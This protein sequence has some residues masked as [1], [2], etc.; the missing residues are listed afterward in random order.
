MGDHDENASSEDSSTNK[1]L[2]PSDFISS[3][4]MSIMG[5]DSGRFF[6]QSSRR[7]KKQE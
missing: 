6:M 1:S 3:E 4:D 5:F 2:E 7:I